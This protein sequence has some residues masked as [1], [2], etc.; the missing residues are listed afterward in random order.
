VTISIIL[1]LHILPQI[2]TLILLMICD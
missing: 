2:W 1:P